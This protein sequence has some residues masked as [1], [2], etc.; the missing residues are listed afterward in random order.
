VLLAFLASRPAPSPQPKAQR[1]VDIEL[2]GQ[3]PAPPPAAAP[4]TPETRPSQRPATASTDRPP[5]KR[6]RPIDRQQEKLAPAPSAPSVAA[7][8]P[9]PEAS[10]PSGLSPAAGSDVPRRAA[11]EGPRGSTL[12][13]IVFGEAGGDAASGAPG[14]G[15]PAPSSAKARRQEAEEI[16]K[17]VDGMLAEAQRAH[18]L[19][20][21]GNDGAVSALGRAFEEAAVSSRGFDPA[22]R[23]WIQKAIAGWLE[24]VRAQH[25]ARRVPPSAASRDTVWEQ[26]KQQA[27]AAVGRADGYVALVEV[28]QG[29]DGRLVDLKLL[30]SSGARDFDARALGS[31]VRG[32]ES[33]PAAPDAGAL[34]PGA[35]SLWQFEGEELPS[36]EVVRA[37]KKAYRIALLDVVPLKE[38]VIELGSK[39]LKYSARLLAIY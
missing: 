1:A 17:R 15:I 16:E 23:T 6:S 18:R 28:R 3:P 20:T 38:T 21:L 32:L 33:A 27:R 19:A 8:E 11:L 24:E 13:N 36:S 30:A 34:G 14:P 31:V 35:L 2:V 26:I 22:E 29:S 39:R 9:A 7:A 12:G 10:A 5:K 37:A 4:P 25:A